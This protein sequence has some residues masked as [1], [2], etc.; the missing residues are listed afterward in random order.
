MR[1]WKTVL[2]EVPNAVPPIPCS[3]NSVA[4]WI[5]LKTGSMWIFGRACGNIPYDGKKRVV[6]SRLSNVAIDFVL[7]YQALT[8]E[9]KSSDMWWSSSGLEEAWFNWLGN[10]SVY[11]TQNI[12]VTGILDIQSRHRHISEHNESE[13]QIFPR[14]S[15][16]QMKKKLSNACCLN[17][18]EVD[19][20]SL[21]KGMKYY[22]CIYATNDVTLIG[23]NEEFK[24]V[25]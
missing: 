5:F 17:N 12:R 7:S 2:R 19:N 9:W 1:E 18:S 22:R 25:R 24:C 6:C 11:K 3:N 14:I 15:N 16:L 20:G 8:G 21:M 13:Q 23:E 4:K 10:P